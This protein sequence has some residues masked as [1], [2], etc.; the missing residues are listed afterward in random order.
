MNANLVK[1][2]RIKNLFVV[3][4]M[5]TVVGC[6]IKTD[7]F[8]TDDRKERVNADLSSL[9]AG[10]DP[11]SGPITLGE[12]IARSLSYNLDHRLKKMESAVAIRRFDFDKH[13]LLP[14]LVAEAGYSERNNDP[15]AR[16]IDL[17]TGEES[18]PPSSSQ[19]RESETR[20]L[21]LTW[22]VLD[23]GLS[24]YIAKQNSDQ[25]YIAEERRRKTVQ[26]ITQDVVDAFWKAWISQNLDSKVEALLAETRAGLAE[27]R[28]LVKR[29]V[30]NSTDALRSQ[31]EMLSTI[32]S[33]IEIRERIDLSRTRLAALINV[34]PGSDYEIAVPAGIDA[35]A[36]IAQSYEQLTKI[37]LLNRPE[38]REEDYRKRISQFDVKKAFLRYFPNLNLNAGYNRDENEFLVNN[39][40]NTIGWGITWDL[41]GILRANSEKKFREAQVDLSDSRRLALSMA[42]TTQVYLSAI[43]YE[44]ALARYES[45]SELFKVRSS[46]ARNSSAQGTR[47]SGLENLSARSASIASELRRNLA[48]AETQAAFARVVNSIG[49]DPIPDTVN[50]YDLKTLANKFD[51]RWASMTKGVLSDF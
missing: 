11:V 49:I 9:Y 26:N 20:N 51:K 14:K 24:Y 4:L 41:L 13:G 3:G 15:G 35:P 27:S 47:V 50:S 12:A 45:A 37:A 18:L 5:T 8:S 44:L 31:G 21:S 29:G 32:D 6:S 38:L 33:L 7:T 28:R 40:W 30:Q 42:V 46:L 17:E 25:I 36:K 34:A 16:S 2:K 22:N 10:Q 23:F 48:F 1:N 43:R 39:S 19:E